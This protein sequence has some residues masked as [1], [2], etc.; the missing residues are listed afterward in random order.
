MSRFIDTK[1]REFGSKH[2]DGTPILN[3]YS[4]VLTNGFEYPGAQAMLY[5]EGIKTKEDMKKKPQVGE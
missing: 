5:A 1:P 4:T 2:D 3:R